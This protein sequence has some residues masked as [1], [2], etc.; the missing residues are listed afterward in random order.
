M[1]SGDKRRAEFL[2]ESAAAAADA[3]TRPDPEA[4][5]IWT[6]LRL[7]QVSLESLRALNVGYEFD[8]AVCCH[9]DSL[10]FAVRF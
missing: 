1:V 2:E 6:R 3:E 5:T 8:P 7:R 10:C 4:K 9:V